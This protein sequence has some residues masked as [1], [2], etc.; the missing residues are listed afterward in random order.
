LYNDYELFKTIMSFIYSL[1]FSETVVLQNLKS[2]PSAEGYGQLAGVSQPDRTVRY[3]TNLNDSGPGSFR[4]AVTSGSNL[5]IVFKVAGTITLSSEI[6]VSGDN[7]HVAGQTAFYNG[8][9]GITIRAN[10]NYNRGLVVFTG[11]HIIVRY[12]RF[13]RGSDN[14]PNGTP[15]GDNLNIFDSSDWIVD[16]C[17]LSWST[18]ENINGVNTIRGT[19]QY[20]ISSEGLYFANHWYSANP[21]DGQ[22]QTGH[23]MGSLFNGNTSTNSKFSFYR[24]LFAHND[25]RNPRIVAPGGT[26][27][28][29]NN[30]MYNNRFFT[31]RF[32]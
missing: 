25:Q 28:L 32:I 26:N 17:S 30:L 3:V 18:D 11:D 1:D 2:F 6:V 19:M 20:S 31:T 27:E 22:Y 12:M 24:N 10:G 14:T 8:G 4:E 16:H 13:R 23:S 29:V 15:V 7:I 5:L 21:N 9:Q